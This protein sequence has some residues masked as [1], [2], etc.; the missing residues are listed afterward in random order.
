[1]TEGQEILREAGIDPIFGQEVLGWA[2][3]RVPGQHSGDTLEELVVELR[4]LR[5]SE[6]PYERYVATLDKFKRQAATRGQ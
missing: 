4:E 1:M 6:A 2:P 3:N 5:K